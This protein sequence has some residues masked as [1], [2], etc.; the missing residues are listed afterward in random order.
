[1]WKSFWGFICHH[2]FSYKTEGNAALFPIFWNVL[3][4]WLNPSN[5]P[6][7][8]PASEGPYSHKRMYAIYG[9]IYHQYT[10]N[11]SIYTIH[12]SYGYEYLWIFVNIYCMT[13]ISVARLPSE[14]QALNDGLISQWPKRGT[15]EVSPTERCIQRFLCPKL[16]R[17]RYTMIIIVLISFDLF[18]H[19]PTVLEMTLSIFI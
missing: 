8:A 6:M 10:P 4:W 18:S 14:K 15:T 1:M 16:A 17:I 13:F 11:V 5:V 12:G 2:Q 9:N 7:K 19:S 3:E